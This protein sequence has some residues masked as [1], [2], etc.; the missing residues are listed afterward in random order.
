M[1]LKITWSYASNLGWRVDF[2]Q[3]SV[4][5]LVFQADYRKRQFAPFFSTTLSSPHW[6]ALSRILG[7]TGFPPVT[8]TGNPDRPLAWETMMVDIFTTFLSILMFIRFLVHTMVSYMTEEQ[9]VASLG[10]T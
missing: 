9:S 7:N 8:K 3:D 1:S 2:S 6:R 10:L 4:C 5:W